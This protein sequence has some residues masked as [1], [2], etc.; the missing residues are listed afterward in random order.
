MVLPVEIIQTIF[1]ELCPPQTAF[2]LHPGELRLLVTSVC[3]QWRAIALSTPALW[4]DFQI[5]ARANLIP[6]LDPIHAWISRAAQSTLSIEIINLDITTFNRLLT[7]PPDALR[8][9]RTIHAF[10]EDDDHEPN[11]TLV[12]TAFSSCSELRTFS[13]NSK[14]IGGYL[15][16]ASFNAPWQ[17]LTTLQLYSNLIPAHECLDIVRRCI[18]LQECYISISA[19][20]DLALQRIIELSRHPTVLPS[21]H[22][23]Y[24][25][26]SNSN[27]DSFMFLHAL[28]LPR[29]RIFQPELERRTHPSPWPSSVLQSVLCDAIQELDIAAFP[30]PESLSEM[31]AR[32]PNL[33]ILHLDGN[34]HEYPG[35]MRALGEG[36]IAPRLTTLYVDFLE[37]PN[38][39]LDILEARVA[40]ARASGNITLLPM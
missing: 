2:P 9:L 18:S 30:I 4:A 24:V 14:R 16:I 35:I 3:S 19:M 8:A 31:L 33:K 38:S 22:T 1:L 17:Q 29:L 23:L 11:P 36:T 26:F 27:N 32:K 15:D 20:D 10:V 12:V 40:A 39:L 28:Y 25:Q 6:Q 7:L 37:S 13:I 34:S 5:H 21:L